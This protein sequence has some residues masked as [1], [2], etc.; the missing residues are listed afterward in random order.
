MLEIDEQLHRLKTL[1]IIDP[2]ECNTEWQK[3]VYNTNLVR[4]IKGMFSTDMPTACLIWRRHSSCVLPHLSEDEL[5]T[6][7]G[8]IPSTT[9]PLNVVL[10]LRQFVPMVSN[11]HPKIMPFITDWSIEMT[12]KLQYSEHWPDIGL[13]FASNILEIFEEVKFIYSWVYY[14]Y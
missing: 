7:L 12:R 5:R 10:W 6:L 8:F 2:Y 3:F 9:E 11:T 13:E 4:V 14:S 1:D